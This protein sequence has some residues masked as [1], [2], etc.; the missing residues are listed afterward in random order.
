[1]R[2]DAE[3]RMSRGVTIALVVI[4]VFAIALLGYFFAVRPQRAEAARL[5]Q[6]IAE[7]QQQLATRRAEL[8][9]ARATRVSAADVRRLG[10]ALPDRLNM[11][12]L[13]LE[14]NG[15]AARAGVTFESVTPQ[16]AVA[17]G[18]Y[19]AAPIALIV[20]GRFFDVRTFFQILRQRAA[21]RSGGGGVGDGQLMGVDSF[22]FAEGEDGFPQIRANITLNAFTYAGAAA[23]PPAAPTT[24]T[25]G[26]TP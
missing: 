2:G 9:Q 22:D 10:A 20:Q 17:V 5:D 3:Q 26:A 24:T 25:T 18:T 14:L 6:Q 15:A 16:P 11:P 12:R 19:Q 4:A 8:A 7:T 1:M 13:I 23:P 21:P